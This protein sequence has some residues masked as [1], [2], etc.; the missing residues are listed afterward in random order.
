MT[1]Q[2]T[3]NNNIN[4][5]GLLPIKNEFINMNNMNQL[6]TN[7]NI[8]LNNY[9]INLSHNIDNNLNMNNYLLLNTNNNVSNINLNSPQNINNYNNTQKNIMFNS[10]QNNFYNNLN[11][12]FYQ[13][14]NN[15]K[16][17][18]LY[19]T[20][21]HIFFSSP[22]LT[23]LNDL[24]YKDF[25]QIEKILTNYK[26]FITNNNYESINICLKYIEFS[27]FFF[28]KN[29]TMK[30]SDIIN[31]IIF[32]NNPDEA[33]KHKLKEVFQNMIPYNI[34]ESYLK[35]FFNPKGAKNIYNLFKKD[36]NL[37]KNE[38]DKIYYLF[39]IY[40][41]IKSKLIN[42]DSEEIIFLLNKYGSNKPNIN[43]N[44]YNN[45]AYYNE[46]SSNKNGG[47]YLNINNY[48]HSNNNY[49]KYRKHSFQSQPYNW[50]ETNNDNKNY[51][52][53]NNHHQHQNYNNNYIEDKNNDELGFNKSYNNSYN[54]KN[55]YKGS[56]SSRHYYNEK[57]M[58]KMKNKSNRKNSNY[59]TGA[60]LVEV[61]TTPKKEEENENEN[62]NV[63]KNEKENVNENE[64]KIEIEQDKKDEIKN[65]IL[66]S[67][68][69]NTN[70][71]NINDKKE[72]NDVN[73][74]NTN[75]EKKEENKILTNEVN[76][77]HDE[78][79]ENIINEKIDNEINTNPNQF[80]NSNGNEEN[81]NSNEDND[82]DN[83]N[84]YEL[85]DENIITDFNS[86]NPFNEN[87][88]E[89]DKSDNENDN[90]DSTKNLKAINTAQDFE[91]SEEENNDENENENEN[92]AFELNIIENSENIFN[93]MN[94][95][96]TNKEEN[97]NNNEYN[98]EIN[99]DNETKENDIQINYNIDNDD[100]NDEMENKNEIKIES[101]PKKE[102]AFSN[103][104]NNI[105]ERI[106]LNKNK[107]QEPNENMMINSNQNEARS[108]S[109]NNL[110]NL[111]KNSKN[112][113][114]NNINI[115]DN[116]PQNNIN[117]NLSTSNDQF[118]LLRMLIQNNNANSLLNLYPF[119]NQNLQK[120]NLN[121]NIL[122][123]ANNLGMNIMNNINT[124]M[125]LLNLIND[126]QINNQNNQIYFQNIEN[127]N[128]INIFL[129]YLDEEKNLIS[130]IKQN[131]KNKTNQYIHQTNTEFLKIKSDICS[132]EYN[133]KLKK[134]KEN[135]PL[136]IKENM[137]LFEEKIILP[138]YQKIH[139]ENEQ[140]K[141]LYRDTFNKYKN[142]IVKVLEKNN[143]K[144]TQ[145][146]PYGSI[147]NN[148]MTEFGDIDVCITP[149]DHNQFKD[150]DK[151]LQEIREEA[152]ENQKYADFIILEQYSKFFILKLKDI[153]TEIDLDI[154]V[155]YILPIINT[156][157]IRLYSLYDQRFHILGIFLKFWVKKNH[158]HG[159]LDKFLSSYALLI[160]IIHYLQTIVEP[161]VLPILQQVHNIKKEYVY[162]N[163]EEE[164]VTNLYFEED[165]DEINKYMN[166]INHDEHNES[167]VVE[168]LVGFFEY[169]SYK[170]THYIISISRSDKVPA[171]ENETIAFPLEDPFDIGYN[172]GKSMKINTLSYTAF[173]YCM[174]KELNNIISG[175]YFKHYKEE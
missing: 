81:I 18:K 37:Y 79:Q 172:P 97:N 91:K 143:V 59:G 84:G 85:K 113:A 65:N 112:N 132:N 107:S 116:V 55:N 98:D 34:R 123:N 93:N 22:S 60:V 169:Y 43:L 158:I 100:K 16:Q 46:N 82:K 39:K 148:F 150:F 117:N 62:E 141:D 51:I 86:I 104:E 105:N 130:V 151:Y 45:N 129:N 174:K 73:V 170:Y 3:Y 4:N 40:E 111:N 71:D 28:D 7:A 19:L 23:K 120:T 14:G 25:S 50:N 56:Y 64:N 127:Q 114:I 42:K 160:L 44:S 165:L 33:I 95:N 69:N 99:I 68:N 106:N 6:N 30:I 156:K 167:T 154:T 89:F 78:N 31:Q 76:I 133:T 126:T 32:S 135:N 94:G 2:N 48:N 145:I 149:S 8:Q 80:V 125:N 13:L 15:N 96:E 109:D 164:K 21:K 155:Q 108:I 61:S 66:E 159:A 92:N 53:G 5:I 142:I 77:S 35:E 137:T 27:N 115:N 124:G 67:N 17:M 138:V 131:S 168:L 72:E 12:N 58:H 87:N 29:I 101:S 157:L 47:N 74:I 121:N 88:K 110:M 9:N 136:L 52:N 24:I 128:Y 173:I 90:E 26:F 134:L 146:E 161:S 118:Q 41:I 49:G 57:N 140:T 144:D 38:K 54:K 10:G 147:V 163:G 1:E 20:S 152:V 83:D 70:N 63:N 175:E 102:I 11:N 103:S 162:H 36:L 75:E 166:I 139:E 171:D 122:S 119:F 153:E